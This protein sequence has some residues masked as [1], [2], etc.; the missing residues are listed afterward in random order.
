MLVVQ[1]GINK[2]I[3]SIKSGNSEAVRVIAMVKSFL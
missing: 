3:A 2:G 1:F